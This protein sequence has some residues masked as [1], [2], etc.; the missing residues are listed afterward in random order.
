MTNEERLTKVFRHVFDDDSIVLS[1]TMTADDIDEWDSLSHV[2]LLIAIEIEFG[3]DFNQNEIY[4]FANVGD[5]LNSIEE[6][7]AGK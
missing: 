1:K 3:F 7:M 5:L 2:N 4:S 6:K